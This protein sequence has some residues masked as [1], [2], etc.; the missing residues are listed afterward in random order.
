MPCEAYVAGVVVVAAD[1]EMPAM[2][3]ALFGAREDGATVETGVH[4]DERT[5]ADVDLVADEV[6]AALV[7]F[8]GEETTLL[9]PD[10][11]AVERIDD[12]ATTRAG[13]WTRL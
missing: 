8:V 12:E 9:G 7:G 13:S 10:R 4:V 6:V 5:E 3:L 1:S 2:E 11:D